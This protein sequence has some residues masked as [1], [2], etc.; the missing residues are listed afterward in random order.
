MLDQ[1]N[2]DSKTNHQKLKNIYS[3]KMR[4]FDDFKAKRREHEEMM[5]NRKKDNASNNKA[6]VRELKEKANRS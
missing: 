6:L 2:K 1:Y 3:M 5:S 4:E